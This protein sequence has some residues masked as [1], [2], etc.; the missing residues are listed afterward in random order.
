MFVCT[1]PLHVPS[2]WDG[3]KGE[4]LKGKVKDKLG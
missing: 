4:Q 3:G 2:V 1:S